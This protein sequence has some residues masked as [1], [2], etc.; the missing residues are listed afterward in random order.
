[1]KMEASSKVYARHLTYNLPLP[2]FCNNPKV[3]I[4]SVYIHVKYAKSFCIHGT[5]PGRIQVRR[6][7]IHRRIPV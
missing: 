4:K 1:M 2:V 5:V 7:R 3:I 6:P